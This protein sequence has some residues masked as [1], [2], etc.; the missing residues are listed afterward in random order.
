M[1]ESEAKL[2][3]S[4]F[5]SVMDYLVYPKDLREL[6]ERVLGDSQNIEMFLENM[7]QAISS[8]VDSTHRTDVQIFLNELRRN[9]TG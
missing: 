9:L 1:L 4:S 3:R 8:E 5:S 7:T 6:T 2:V